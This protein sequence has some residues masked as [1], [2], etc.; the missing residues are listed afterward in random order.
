L[1]RVDEARLAVRRLIAEHGAD[2][3]EARIA[4]GLRQ[5]DVARAVHRSASSIGRVERN[6]ARRVALEA[7]ATH[8]AAVGLTLSTRL[9]PRAGRLR[10]ASQ[11][12]M[13]NT[14]RELIAPGGWSIALE[15][16]VGDDRDLRA[17]DMVLSR[18]SVQIAHEFVSRVRDVQAQIRPLLR[19]QHDSGIRRLVLVVAGTHA[20]RRAVAEA[21]MA[22]RDA[23]PLGSKGVLAAL[24][25]GRDP[26][27]NGLVFLVATATRPQPQGGHIGQEKV[28]TWPPRLPSGQTAIQRG[29]ED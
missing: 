27:Q 21:G 15:V 24:R 23:F 16:P 26:G 19:K 4:A 25:A 9:Y 18:S 12:G 3:R 6:A 2:L 14:Y 1:T 13:I 17:F 8:A 28:N 10:D 7:L 11:L 5:G 20:N 22:I 29:V